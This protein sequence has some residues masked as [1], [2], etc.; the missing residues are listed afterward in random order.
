MDFADD[1]PDG[2]A[3]V[4]LLGDEMHVHA[5]GADVIA[6]GSAPCQPAARRGLE[7]LQDGRGIVIAE[8]DGDDVRLIA[9]GRDAGG[10]GQ[11]GRGGDAGSF[12]VAGILEEILHGAALDA[13]VRPPGT[14]RARDRLCSSRRP[15][16]RSR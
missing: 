3:L 1:V 11:V 8:G 5:A 4:V 6:E 7:R 12:R 2:A 15:A 9:V 10:V 14:V 16:G 13:G